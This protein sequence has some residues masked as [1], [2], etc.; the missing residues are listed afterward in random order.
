[1][2]SFLDFFGGRFGL[3]SKLTLFLNRKILLLIIG[4][5]YR[6]NRMNERFDFVKSSDSLLN[7]VFC[8]FY[9]KIEIDFL[10][11]I[12]FCNSIGFIQL[13]GIVQ[14]IR[15]MKE[16][17]SSTQWAF[18]ISLGV[19]FG[20]KSKSTLFK[21]DINSFLKSKN[22]DSDILYMQIVQKNFLL[23]IC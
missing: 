3:K 5:L 10:L 18:L 19:D 21:I 15:R 16:L 13:V 23:K 20:L 4:W 14:L 6:T 2:T 12:E 9:G 1:M 8:W 7:Q 11:N 17:I 22:I